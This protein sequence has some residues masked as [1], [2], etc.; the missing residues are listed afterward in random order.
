M[1]RKIQDLR[2][3]LERQG[4]GAPSLEGGVQVPDELAAGP[5]NDVNTYHLL[6]N[7]CCNKDIRKAVVSLDESFPYLLNTHVIFIERKFLKN[8]LKSY[9]LPLR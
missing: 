3:T 1:N 6:Q 2:S 8:T 9:F 5:I 4:C 7:K